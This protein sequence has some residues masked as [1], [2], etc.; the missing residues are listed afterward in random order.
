MH[1]TDNGT[2][3]QLVGDIGGTNARFATLAAPG[4]ALS[5]ID[6]LACA[7]YPGP[8]AAIKAY[9]ARHS[10]PTPCAAAAG[11]ANPV[12]GDAIRMTNHSWAFSIEAE[13]QAA[14]LRKL[15]FINDFTALALS[16]PHLGEDERFQVG[17]GQAQK[18]APIGV[19]GPG[20][21]LGVS[22]LI[23]YPGG[24]YAPLQGEGGHVTLT[25][26]SDEELAVLSALMRRYEHVSAE[27]AV[28]GPGMTALYQALAEVRGGS[29]EP[30]EAPEITERA[31]HGTDK[32]CVDTCN[33]FCALLATSAADLALTL[34]AFGGI[35]IGGGIVPKLGDFFV[36]SPFRARFENK[37][38]FS[39]YLSRIPTFVITAKYPA[40]TGSAVALETALRNEP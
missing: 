38:R 12:T 23:P 3:P 13:R 9:L 39:Q 26:Q 22:G 20:T 8:A 1:T 11:I 16:L 21:G 27:R 4:A 33:M 5:H 40:L 17:G 15:V 14:G 7:D 24:H 25:G 35:F 36:K 6:T 30:L 2:Y 34:G 31:V 32:L 10:L 18:G 37:G 28:S 29:V 19:I